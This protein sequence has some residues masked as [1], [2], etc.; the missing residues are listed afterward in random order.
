[1]KGSNFRFKD[2]AV[3]INKN[4][5]SASEVLAAA[6]KDNEVATIVGNTSYGKGTSQEIKMFSDGS[7]LKYTSAIWLSPKDHEINNQGITPDHLVDMPS[8]L[9]LPM[10][11]F[12]DK[13]LVVKFDSVNIFTAQIQQGLNM[14]GYSNRVDGYYDQ[15]TLNNLKDFCQKNGISY[16]KDVNYDYYH[17]IINKFLSYWLDNPLKVDSQLIKALEL[18]K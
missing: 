6:L 1:S 13:E 15:I 12:T 10:T 14:L 17:Q 9:A 4:S 5:A 7:A 3:I 2:V 16:Q 11:D 18:I 8:F